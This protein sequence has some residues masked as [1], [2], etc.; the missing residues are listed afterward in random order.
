MTDTHTDDLASLY[1]GPLDG[2]TVEV[3]SHTHGYADES[4]GAVYS[5]CPHATKRLGKTTFIHTHVAH[6]ALAD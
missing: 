1:G 2:E 5:Y 6:D 4:T 3:G